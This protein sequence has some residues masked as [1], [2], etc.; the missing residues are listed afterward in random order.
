MTFFK[1]S[2]EKLAAQINDVYH[3]G[4]TIQFNDSQ[5]GMIDGLENNRFWV[6]ISARRTGKSFAASILALAK[7]LEPNRQVMVV[8]PN[9]NLSSIIW[10][11]V[12]GFIKQLGLECDKFNQKDKIVALVNGSTFRLLSAN[13]RDS[14]VGRAAHLLIV[15]EAAVIDSDEYYNRDLRPALST[16]KDSRA[17]F[18][19]TPRGKANYIYDYYLRGNELHDEYP[20]WGSA[21]YDWTS[22]PMLS[23]SDVNEARKS[24][25]E[26]LFLQEYYCEW[27]TFE[28]QIYTS[29]DEQRHM[30]NVVETVKL[31]HLEVIGG[32]DM[33]FR[34]STA[35][36][37]I[38]TD[39]ENY[40][41]LDCYINS[42]GATSQH[43]EVIKEL[44]EKWNIDLIYID[45]AAAQTKAD[46]AYDY[47]IFCENSIKSVND[48][49][50]FIQSL[51]EKDRL[52]FDENNTIPV[53]Q[54]MAA[55]RWNPKTETQK[56]IHD[57]ASHFCDALR[58]AIYTYSQ[59]QVGLY[60][61]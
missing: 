47:D 50:A 39:T 31:E 58:Y 27:T 4:K 42:E 32:L 12:T 37:V 25:P 44:E 41:V 18:I 22:N 33:G 11:Y 53:F 52:F 6:H 26:S 1:I 16:F 29:I 10:D 49:I 14:L 2:V 24:I 46:L 9:Y 23:E 34:D 7:L 57:N 38:G 35:F 40:Y 59:S 48:G 54:A 21:R 13:N 61:M 17:L 8:A 60:A 20:D 43:A 28:G 15:D 45:S 3:P 51:L 56:P 5:Q 36:V 19:T 55:Y 30:I